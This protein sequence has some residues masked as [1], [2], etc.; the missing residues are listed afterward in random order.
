MQDVRDVTGRD[1]STG[2]GNR[3]KAQLKRSRFSV[4]VR[5]LR[6][7]RDYRLILG[8]LFSPAGAKRRCGLSRMIVVTARLILWVVDDDCDESAVFGG[9]EF[10]VYVEWNGYL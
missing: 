8:L 9:I 3:A 4:G 5:V 6:D 2:I 7:S 10:S 1:R